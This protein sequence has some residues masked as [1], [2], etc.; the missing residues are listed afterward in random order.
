MRTPHQT[1]QDLRHELHWLQRRR[2]IRRNMMQTGTHNDG[3]PIYG[4]RRTLSRRELRKV[5]K[6]VIEDL[7]HQARATQTEYAIHR[8]SNPAAPEH[9]HDYC[10]PG[11]QNAIDR[12]NHHNN[13]PHYEGTD[14]EPIQRA[15]PAWH[16]VN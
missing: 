7:K 16:P 4:P 3:T 1:Y 13:S 6:A 12:A 8:R 9:P 15:L 10:Y 11:R 2:W 5:K 14:W